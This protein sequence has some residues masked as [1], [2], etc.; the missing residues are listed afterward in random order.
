VVRS[1]LM[2]QYNALRSLKMS[3]TLLAVDFVIIASVRCTH[4]G[5]PRSVF[6]LP[7]AHIHVL[8]SASVPEDMNGVEIILTRRRAFFSDAF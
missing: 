2:G 7:A 6:I 3:G 1:Y 5:Y 4:Q 8:I